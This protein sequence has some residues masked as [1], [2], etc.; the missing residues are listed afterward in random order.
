MRIRVGMKN[1]P[2][3]FR[4]SFIGRKRA[5]QIRVI[6][7]LLASAVY[8]LAAQHKLVQPDVHQRSSPTPEVAIV[9]PSAVPVATYG[10]VLAT[11]TYVVDGDTIRVE[12][13]E[14]VRYIGMNTPETVAPGRGVECFGKE[15][16]MRNKALVSGKTVELERDVTNRD[17]YG[18]LLR[19]VWIGETL[20]SEVLVREGYAQVSTYPPDVKYQSR[21]VEAQ[22]LAVEEKRGLWSGECP[23]PPVHTPKGPTATPPL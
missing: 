5:L 1:F 14:T 20:V 8:A 13:G 22:R 15:A 3:S 18:R 6:I 4:M 9:R 7:F 16:S 11:V 19:H 2:A 21:L 23:L 10:G 12:G 17:K